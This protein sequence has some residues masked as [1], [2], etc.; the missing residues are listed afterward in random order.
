[1]SNSE[2]RRAV[3]CSQQGGELACLNFLL[4]N[5]KVAPLT[6]IA[7]FRTPHA[8][9]SE[10][11]RALPSEIRRATECAGLCN[12]FRVSYRTAFHCFWRMR[13]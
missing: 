5:Q 13:V 12:T 3:L 1:M 4:F 2:Q 10:T 7:E 6:F 9:V 11:R 8:S